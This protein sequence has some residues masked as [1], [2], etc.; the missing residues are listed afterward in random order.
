[1]KLEREK[2][3]L[4]R[5][6]SNLLIA[7]TEES[8]Y[9]PDA[10]EVKGFIKLYAPRVCV[11]SPKPDGKGMDLTLVPYGVISK[12]TFLSDLIDNT[13]YKVFFNMDD[14][15]SIIPQ[16]DIGTAIINLYISTLSSLIM[17]TVITDKISPM[18]MS[19]AKQ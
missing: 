8:I 6:K 9:D 7:M 13:N 18:S 16:E 5:T 11:I 3:V 17:P 12:K 2:I 4:F 19:E 15:E 1:M 10:N 14:I